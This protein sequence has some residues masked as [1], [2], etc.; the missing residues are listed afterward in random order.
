MPGDT[1]HKAFIM[2]RGALAEY[3]EK[4]LLYSLKCRIGSSKAAQLSI[5]PIFP[6]PFWHDKGKTTKVLSSS[7]T[8]L[9]FERKHTF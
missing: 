2:V 1:I 6:N 3:M 4:Q 8:R 9:Y 5:G 7:C